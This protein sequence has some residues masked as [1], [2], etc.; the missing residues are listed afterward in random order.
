LTLAGQYYI[1][2]EA[3]YVPIYGAQG[4]IL[5]FG[6][7]WPFDNSVES[8]NSYWYTISTLTDS[9]NSKLQMRPL[10]GL[11]SVRLQQGQQIMNHTKCDYPRS[12]IDIISKHY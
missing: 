11:S 10:V 7:F 6:G 2:G 12:A 1:L 4:V 3:Q 9:S 5:F 8:R